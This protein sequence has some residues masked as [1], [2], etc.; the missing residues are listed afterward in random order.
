MQLAKLMTNILPI[1]YQ[2]IETQARKEKSSKRD[3]VERAI[4]LYMAEEQKKSI[5]NQ[6]EK[7]SEDKAYQKEMRHMAKM[8]M[9]YYLKDIDQNAD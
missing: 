9:N 1:Y 8:G 6:Y 2:F 3:V 7:M 4:A 5:W